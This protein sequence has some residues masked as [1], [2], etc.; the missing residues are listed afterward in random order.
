M[1]INIHD[2]LSEE[3]IKDICIEELRKA[4]KR[5]FRNE[6][7][8]KR[9]LSNLSYEYV[10]DQ[11]VCNIDE[12]DARKIIAENVERIIIDPDSLKFEV[13]RSANGYGDKDS[14]ARKILNEVLSEQKPLIEQEVK[15]R[16]QEYPF[17]ELRDDIEQT[18]YECVVRM[19]RG[20]K[21]E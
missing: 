6:N 21:N 18:I 4:Y 10:F 1:E 8:I 3:E 16:I 11:I 5:E 2:Y 14:P 20:E 15:K 17:Y 19:I 13:F 12:V 9:I 7:D